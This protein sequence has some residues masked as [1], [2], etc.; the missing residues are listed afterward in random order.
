MIDGQSVTRDCPKLSEKKL[1]SQKNDGQNEKN[2]NLK[3]LHFPI[4]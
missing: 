1:K 3:K 2:Q 4:M